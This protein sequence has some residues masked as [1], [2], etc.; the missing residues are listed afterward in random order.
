MAARNTPAAPVAEPQKAVSEDAEEIVISAEN[1]TETQKNFIKYIGMATRRVITKKDWKAVGI[2][3]DDVKEVIWDFSNGM[4][5]P[6]E[7]FN[8]QQLSYLL[9]ADGRFKAVDK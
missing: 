3:G 9:K 2:E 8:G 4:K 6:A 5:L 1:G 7:G